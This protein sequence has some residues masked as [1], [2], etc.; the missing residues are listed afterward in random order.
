VAGI[1]YDIENSQMLYKRDLEAFKLR[2]DKLFDWRDSD[3]T[4]YMAPYFPLIQSSGTGKTKLM[5]EYKKIMDQA[6]ADAVH[7]ELVLCQDGNADNMTSAN[8]IFSKTLDISQI[9]VGEEGRKELWELLNT[10]VPKEKKKVALLFD[11]SQHLTSKGDGWHFRSIRWWLRSPGKPDGLNVVC[12]F[13]GTTTR[14]AN[15]YAEPKPSNSSR[16]ANIT[17]LGGKK[18]YPPFYQ[19]TT[20]GLVSLTDGSEFGNAGELC[21]NTNEKITEFDVAAQYGRP[22]FGRMHLKRK[23]EPALGQILFRMRGGGRELSLQKY[24]SL[25]AVRLQMGQVSFDFASE[26]VALG[27]AHLT[28]FTPEHTAVAEIAFLPDPV[29]AWLAMT[30]MIK[31]CN[32]FEDVDGISM[33]C[34]EH[35]SVW[36]EKAIKIYSSALCRPAKGD[37][38][39]VA[40]A[41]YMLACGDELRRKQSTDLKQLSVPLEKWIEELQGR[42][43]DGKGTVHVESAGASV[44]FIQVCRNHLRHSLKEINDSALLKHWYRGGRASYGYAS[45]PAYDMV[46]PL[47]YTFNE[48]L[49]YCPM[50]VSVKNRLSYST[51]QRQAAIEA[52]EGIFRD[53]KLETGVCMLLLIGLETTKKAFSTFQFSHDNVSTLEIEVPNEDKFGATNLALCSTCGG[54][55]EAEV[56]VSHADLAL[57]ADSKFACLLRSKTKDNDPSKK[58]LNEITEGYSISRLSDETSSAET[59]ATYAKQS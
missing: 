32:L 25:L 1:D 14:L 17:Y 56:M 13:A 52:M 47:Q 42:A 26:L 57:G 58:L 18:L 27:Y 10:F 16:S 7:V 40:A 22:L 55:E 9:P 51:K 30:Q 28:H 33:G 15:Y 44:S 59:V 45:C 3:S 8:D 50:L 39:E 5:H 38:G 2:V 21:K 36:S 29:C 53:A 54:G 41:F 31:G 43:S 37:V 48:R 46:V 35:A 23:L 19:I 24:Y 34:G 20:T 4:D 6:K 12:V 11:E 49:H